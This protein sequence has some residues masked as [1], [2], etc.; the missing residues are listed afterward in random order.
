MLFC[1]NPELKM[2]TIQNGKYQRR[3]VSRTALKIA[4][5]KLGGKHQKT[6]ERILNIADH[7]PYVWFTEKGQVF[8]SWGRWGCITPAPH[9]K[10]E[11]VI[12]CNTAKCVG[13]NKET[14]SPKIQPN[15]P[16]KN[17]L[18]LL[19]VQLLNETGKNV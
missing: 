9:R 14:P 18:N 4:A 10:K 8:R 2:F 13:E 19:A 6:C 15:I 7:R 12:L 1:Y 3:L 16:Q 17:M 11:K 5:E